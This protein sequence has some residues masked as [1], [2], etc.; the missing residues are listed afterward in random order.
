MGFVELRQILDINVTSL[1]DIDEQR[2]HAGWIGASRERKSL[3]QMVSFNLFH[4]CRPVK[5]KKLCRPVFDPFGLFERLNNEGFF[6]L[7]YS[8]IQAYPIL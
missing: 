8:S 7:T 3:L 6:K 5:M 2:S 1:T 4:K